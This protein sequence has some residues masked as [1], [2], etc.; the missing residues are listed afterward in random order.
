MGRFSS[1]RTDL[2]MSSF[3]FCSSC[4]PWEK[5]SRATFS[6]ARHMSAN[7]ARS[8]LAGPMV[9]TILVFLI[10]VSL[11]CYPLGRSARRANCPSRRSVS[12]IHNNTGIPLPSQ[13]YVTKARPRISSDI[14]GF[15]ARDFDPR[16]DLKDA[17]IQGVFQVLQTAALGQ[18]IRRKKDRTGGSVLKS[19]QKLLKAPVFRRPMRIERGLALYDRLHRSHQRPLF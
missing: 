4:V 6:P 7:T 17:D 16:Q 10:A 15:S 2:I 13:Q 8:L 19:K 3:A 14:L 1:S 11:L 5:F 9:H 18:K 12:Q